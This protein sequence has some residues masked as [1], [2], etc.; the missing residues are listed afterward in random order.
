[1]FIVFMFL[2]VNCKWGQWSEWNINATCG[3]A[4]KTKTRKIIQKAAYGG[5]QCE[6]SSVETK[7]FQLPPCQSKWTNQILVLK[8]SMCCSH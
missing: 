8:Y 3:E 4:F 6:G 2:L 1:M 7:K 5:K